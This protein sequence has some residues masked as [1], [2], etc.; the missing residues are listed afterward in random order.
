MKEHS[1]IWD[2]VPLQVCTASAEVSTRNSTEGP[3]Q[4]LKV[5][6]SGFELRFHPPCR[7]TGEAGADEKYQP[8]GPWPHQAAP[9]RPLR[10]SLPD[11]VATSLKRGCTCTRLPRVGHKTFS[12]QLFGIGYC[13]LCL[14]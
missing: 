13:C 7:S 9:L 10:I 3:H 11:M 12:I 8:K 2:T 14:T 1:N 6:S 5:S 4:K